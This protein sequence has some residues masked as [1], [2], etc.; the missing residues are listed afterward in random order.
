MY[1]KQLRLIIWLMAMK[2]EAENENRSQ[3]CGIKGLG[4]NMN[5]KYTKKKTRLNI[6]MVICIKKHPNNISSSVYEEG[7]QHCGWVE[8]I[9]SLS[10]GV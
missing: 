6:M 1:K 3:R 5:K 7:K 10:I 8:N 9:K 2:N 4:L